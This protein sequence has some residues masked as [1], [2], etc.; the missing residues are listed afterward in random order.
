[1]HKIGHGVYV[2]PVIHHSRED[3][4]PTIPR[5]PGWRG[6]IDAILD[7]GHRHF[8][9]KTPKDLGFTLGCDEDMATCLG[10]PALV[11]P[12][13][14]TFAPVNP[15]HGYGGCARVVEPLLRVDID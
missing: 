6:P 14:D 1:M 13:Q 2:R 8:R 3:Q 4:S 11:P 5:W 10:D 7:R 15:F 12:Q 9:S